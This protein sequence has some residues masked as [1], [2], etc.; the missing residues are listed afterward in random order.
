MKLMIFRIIQEQVSN[1]IRHSGANSIT[2][3]LQSDAEFIV[4]SIEDNGQGFDPQHHKKGMGLKNI[5]NRVALFDGRV[6][7]ESAPGKGCSVT[8][9][10]P[11][12]PM[13]G[14]FN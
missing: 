8:V 6:D 14:L 13:N 2:I 3:K 11:V 4:F 10:I 7:I 1:I 12:P 9:N 5:A